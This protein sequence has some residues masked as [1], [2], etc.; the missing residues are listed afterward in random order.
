M[1][2][3]SQNLVTRFSSL[4]AQP[5]ARQLRLL[6]GLAASI[7]LGLSLVQW[8]SSP[9][10]TPLYGELSPSASAEIISSLEASGVRYTV[11]GPAGIVSV[12][13]NKVSQ[14]RLQLAAE[15][16][17][18]SDGAG[19]DML[20]EEPRMGVSSFM[21][22]ARY[23]HALE[24]ELAKSVTSLDSVRSAVVH[25]ALPKQSAFVRKK[26]NPAA[27][28]LVNLYAGRKLTERQLAGVVHM[29]AYSVP[30][31]EA[32]Q[33]SV[34]DNRG[35]LLSS[36]TGDGDAEYI[37]ENL[38]YSQQL[39]QSYVDRIDEILTPVMGVNAM[40]A[41]VVAIIDFTSTEQ[42][43]ENYGPE[44]R[45]RSEQLSEEINNNRDIM[46]GVPGTLSNQPPAEA[47]IAREGDAG[48][49]DEDPLVP[50]ARSTKQEV[51]NYELDKTIS[52]I[53]QTPGTLLKL[54]VAV[55]VDY[56]EAVNADGVSE[57]QPLSEE[58]MAEITGLVR[59][60]VGFDE[61]R[62]DTL[63]VVNT[64]FV[65]VPIDETVL[66]SSLVD[67][68]WFWRSI[69]YALGSLATL[70]VIFTVVRPLMQASSHSP[71]VG[72]ASLGGPAGGGDYTAAS[73]AGMAIG[74]D[75]VTLGNQHQ[76]GAPAYQ[77]QLT[78]ARS[79]VEGEPERAAHVVKNWMTD[80]G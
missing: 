15:G 22:K 64:S 31:L 1:A 23:D 8:A 29:I 35:N 78:M 51:R 21:E 32:E 66:E 2:L 80:D 34:V 33:V 55:V 14:L 19:F 42:T 50:P 24:E 26:N 30:G 77:Q 41:Q 71:P 59:Q 16:L 27:S 74:D 43:L 70:L 48:E 47:V 68:E 38:R 39:E 17:P 79:M 44:T 61:A 7:A 28:V 45:I 76:L 18:K 49:T 73:P 25:L 75:R 65:V 60:A 72:R 67:Q 57:R 62:G 13:T 58:R 54:S 12:P 9:D 10:F 56:Q 40:R 63:E 46:G 36:Q 20:Y 37:R 3:D 11:N 69:K 5:G 52:H 4:S 53:R 6:L